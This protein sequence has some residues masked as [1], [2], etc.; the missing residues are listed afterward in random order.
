MRLLI[1]LFLGITTATTAP[2]TDTNAKKVDQLFAAFE[3]PGSPG[4]SVGIIRNSSFVY[5][6]SFGYASLEF[7]V[8]LTPESV[9]Y[10]ASVSKQFTA[11]SVVL[12]AEQ[13]YLSLDDDVHKYLPER[14]QLRPRE[15]GPAQG[16][17]NRR[18]LVHSVP[19]HLRLCRM[20][21]HKSECPVQSSKR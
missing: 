11:A 2:A 17:H 19:A 14:H 16:L 5:K 18:G 7:G 20:P 10:V 6:K 21:I 15:A 4:C 8:P 9:F 12:A 13:G 1:V 3:K